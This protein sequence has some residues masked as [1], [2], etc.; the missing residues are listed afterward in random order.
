MH[1][2]NRFR[3]VRARLFSGLTVPATRILRRSSRDRSRQYLLFNQDTDK[4]LMHLLRKGQKTA[5]GD[6]VGKTII[7]AKNWSSSPSA[8]PS[9]HVRPEKETPQPKPISME[10]RPKP[11]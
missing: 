6:R 1:L 8:E 11:D 7:L 2:G 4:V 10:T 5:S 9:K 3:H